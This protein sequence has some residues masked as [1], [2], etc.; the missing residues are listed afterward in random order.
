MAVSKV[1]ST[2]IFFI[3]CDQLYDTVYTK[4]TMW[5]SLIK[6]VLKA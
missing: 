6:K 3:F 4:S 5:Y 2:Q 1:L